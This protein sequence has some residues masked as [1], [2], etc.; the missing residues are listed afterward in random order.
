MSSP[1]FTPPRE[2]EYVWQLAT[3][4]PAQGDWSE[5]A[6]LDL[7]DGTSKLIEFTDGRLE[8][9]P[10]PTEVHQAL[11]EYLFLALRNFVQQH[12]LGLV[13]FAG[14]RLR[15]RPG[16]IRQPD[17]LFLHKDRY[18]V[19]HNRVWDGAD[20]VMEV[21]SDDPKDRKRDY[22]EKLADYADGKVAEYWVVDPEQ[23]VVIVHFLRGDRY[24]VQGEFQAGEH[25]PST[26]LH[27]FTVDVGGLF[28]VIE[29]IPD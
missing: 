15:V 2:P 24:V 16:K 3:L 14:L 23:R 7:T 18:H 12:Q 27:G 22:E 26:L 4:F 19:R 9:L 20:L 25:A 28:A 1:P 17:V 5:T 8:F 11:I 29:D 13:R 10:M 6:Y 21:V